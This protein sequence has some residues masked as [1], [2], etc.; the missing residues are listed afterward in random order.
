MREQ[1]GFGMETDVPPDIE[2]FASRKG[3]SGCNKDSYYFYT[4]LKLFCNKNNE[5][6]V[7]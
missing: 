7:D 2:E 4:I 1:S 6:D 5:S 3:E